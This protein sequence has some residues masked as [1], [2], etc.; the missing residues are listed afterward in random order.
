MK[1]KISKRRHQIACK[2]EMKR[3]LLGECDKIPL[4]YIC[5]IIIFMSKR[6]AEVIS[7]EVDLLI[8][9]LYNSLAIKKS[10]H[11]VIM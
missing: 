8:A 10:I 4:I 5:K 2:E 9:K 1:L 6:C 3:V 7:K 11:L